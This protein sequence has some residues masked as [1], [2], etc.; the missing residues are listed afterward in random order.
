MSDW[1]RFLRLA[2]GLFAALTLGMLALIVWANPYRNLP[3]V[4]TDRPLMDGNQR[5]MYPSIARDLSFDSG[6]FGNSSVRFLPPA[7]LDR[8]L[9]GSFA[10]LGMDAA[11]P[12]EQM[13]LARLFHEVRAP[14][15]PAT[16]IHG[17]GAAWC[18]REE[19]YR[20]FTPRPFPEWMYDHNPWNDALYVL[21]SGT[22]EVTGRVLLYKLGLRDR[23]HFEPN[24]FGDALPDK[25]KFDLARVRKI[26]Y[27][28]E[29][30]KPVE[31]ADPPVVLSAGER[32]SWVYATH[33]LFG[34]LLDLSPPATRMIVMFVPYH[35]YVL[36]RPGSEEEQ[37]LIECKTR[38]ARMASS[39]PNTLVLDFMR[40]SRINADERN[41]W[42]QVHFGHDTAAEIV[43]AISA[44]VQGQNDETIA[45]VLHDG[46][47]RQ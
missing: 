28:S 17:I 43:L 19:S 7:L 2:I 26:I 32:A 35:E 1:T 15:A 36:P 38:I 22:L 45:T 29:E 39:R 23:M 42:D 47:M 4:G 10:V 5:Y 21:N 24:G 12:Y 11:T 3:F 31:P 25:S 34:E 8:E 44:A 14:A 6:V 46:L 16:V 27:G 13:R 20:R 37:S 33:E 41:Y 40:P 30:P 9:G 18:E